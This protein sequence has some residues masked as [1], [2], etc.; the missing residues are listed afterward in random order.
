MRFED[1]RQVGLRRAPA[2]NGQKSSGGRD[3]GQ[4]LYAIRLY[5]ENQIRFVRR[6]VHV[7]SLT[8]RGII[9]RAA[10]RPAMPKSIG[11]KAAP[12]RSGRIPS[13]GQPSGNVEKRCRE[14]PTP[15]GNGSYAGSRRPKE[16]VYRPLFRGVYKSMIPR[17]S[18]I[19]TAWVRSLARSLMRILLT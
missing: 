15:N 4:Q 3:H 19:V 8:S 10:S 18:P 7:P 2:R 13:P 1:T 17:F 9:P 16:R 12:K 5:A 11:A 6:P 14:R